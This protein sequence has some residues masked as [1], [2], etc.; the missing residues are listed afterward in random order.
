MNDQQ[1]ERLR[2]LFEEY[3]RLLEEN[4]G[5]NFTRAVRGILGILY[6]ESCSIDNRIEEARQ[7]FRSMIGGPGTLG[8]FAIWHKDID[9]QLKLNQY[10][11]KIEDEIW[12]LLNIGL[13]ELPDVDEGYPPG[14]IYWTI[15]DP[16]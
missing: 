14:H 7:T 6:D 10:L 9:I 8:D 5:H 2:Y 15:K 16:E 11:N 13:P 12:E 3:L 1:L 4:S